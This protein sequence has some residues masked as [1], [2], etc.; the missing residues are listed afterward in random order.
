MS[1][2][3][4]SDVA[5]DPRARFGLDVAVTVEPGEVVAVLGSN[6]AGKSTLLG[7]LAGLHRPT[8]G[9]VVLGDRPLA[10]ACPCTGGGS[11]CSASRRCSSRT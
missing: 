1:R 6:G 8:R 10:R 4:T 11:G 3:A 7:T 9:E 2:A 5:V